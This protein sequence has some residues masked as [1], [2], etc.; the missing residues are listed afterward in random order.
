[1]PKFAGVTS[2]EKYRQVFD[3]IVLSNGWDNAT[4]ALQLLS[5]LEGD[6][7][8]VALLVPES[9]QASQVGLVGALSAHY[10]SPRRLADYRRQFERTTRT[11]GED[12]SIFATAGDVGNKGLWRHGSDGTTSDY[13]RSIRSGQCATCMRGLCWGGGGGVAAVMTSPVVFAEDITEGVMLPTVA[14]AASLTD[15]AEVVAADATSLADAAMVTIGVAVS[16]DAGAASL[17]NAGILF[18]AD[19]ARCD[20][21]G[22][23]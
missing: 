22:R 20:I 3:A 13:P 2:W 4:A 17:A 6:A 18:P 8:N 9:R 15:F 21:P 14:G 16:A 10:G 1:M 11:F 7:L 12:L 5:H 23:C 19:L